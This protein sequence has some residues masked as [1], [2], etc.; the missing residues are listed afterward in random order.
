MSDPIRWRA[1]DGSAPA[2]VRE[3]LQ[4]ASA[5][6]GMDAATRARHAAAIAEVTAGAAPVAAAGTKMALGAKLLAGIGLAAAVAVGAAPAVRARRAQPEA[7]VAIPSA[8]PTAPRAAPVPLATTETPLT[9]APV[10]ATQRPVPLPTTP[11][12]VA[13]TRPSRPS[14]RGPIE[15]A[16][17]TSPPTVAV[18]PAPGA[19]DIVGAPINAGAAPAMDHEDPLTRESNLINAA[20]AALARD[21]QEALAQLARHEREFPRGQHAEDREFVAV[22]AL[23]DLGRNAEART[24]AQSLIARFP[25]SPLRGRAQRLIDALP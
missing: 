2:G 21:P 6:K 1:S 5:P 4:Q 15:G 9:E 10:A 12:L 7:R 20:N 11:P 16:A 25:D 17:Q 23:R 18:E 19:T 24:R 8:R 22:Q 14:P 13:P 3:L